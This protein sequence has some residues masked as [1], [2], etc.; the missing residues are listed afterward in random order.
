MS[1]NKIKYILISLVLVS[2]FLLL[3][4]SFRRKKETT[5]DITPTPT[6][7]M[8][9]IELENRPYISLIPRTD[10][11]ELKLK[12]EKIPENIG[13]IEYELIYSATDNDL[14]IEKGLGDTIQVDSDS[15]ERDLLLGTASCTNSCKYKY[16]E[17]ITG[18]TLSILFITKNSQ[19]ATYQT[20]FLLT[21]T[22]AIKQ[23]SGLSLEPE[24]FNIT[25]T[26]NTNEYF[27]LL[28]NYNENFS[29]FS[30][31]SGKGKI[32]KIEPENYTKEDTSL[33]TG[34]YVKN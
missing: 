10:G 27:I 12:I 21:D 17:G 23:N 15:L 7:R 8:T 25:A 3:F 32:S 26:A 9:E 20:A 14:E 5:N 1:N 29:V 28:K 19:V 22:T 11:H 2:L 34:D 24:N 4:F 31:D 6:P 18:G 30:S 13:E 16:D 33:I